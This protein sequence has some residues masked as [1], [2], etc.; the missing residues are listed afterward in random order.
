M[1]TVSNPTHDPASCI[2]VELRGV[3]KAYQG[4]TALCDINLTLRCGEIVGFV[5]P[6]GA[7]KSTL[8]K[9]IAGLVRPGEGEGSVMNLRISPRRAPSPFVGMMLEKPSFVEH[10]SGRANLRLLAGIRGVI[11]DAEIADMLR[12]VGLEG[13]GRKAVRGYS[14]GMRQR[15]SLAQAWME[16]PRLILLDE[17]T[18]GLDPAAV[19][20]R[21]APSYG[22]WP[23]RAPRCCWR[24]TC[25]PRSRQSATG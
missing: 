24:A 13:V 23:M 20:L 19:L 6:N 7:G 4:T 8:L 3:G 21:C 18:N 22:R 9:I 15:L 2:A 11:G 14:Q 1:T 25:S 17:P 12:T 5:G 16:H 10:R